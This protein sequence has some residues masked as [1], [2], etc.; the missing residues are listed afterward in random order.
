MEFTGTLD[1]KGRDVLIVDDIVSAGS[2]ILGA[3]KSLVNVR[4]MDVAIIHAVLPDMPTVDKGDRLVKR[5]LAEKKIREFVATDTVD[6]EFGKA[7]V[8]DDIVNF[9]RTHK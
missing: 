1:A 5:L 3:M 4:M 2:T 7:S 6:S 9:Y 8:I